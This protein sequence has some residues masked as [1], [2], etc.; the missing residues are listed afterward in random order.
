MQ[1]A[2]AEASLP[3]KNAD[4]AASYKKGWSGKTKKIARSITVL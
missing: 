2:K 1:A 3:T 4:T